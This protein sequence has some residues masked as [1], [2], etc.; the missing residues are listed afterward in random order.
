MQKCFE[1]PS[2][3]ITVKVSRIIQV[4]ETVQDTSI[5]RVSVY[6]EEVMSLQKIV[7]LSQILFFYLGVSLSFQAGNKIRQVCFKTSL[8][9]DHAFNFTP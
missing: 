1:Y 2:K 3:P 9:T 8:Y 5:E 7:H 6:I 4:S